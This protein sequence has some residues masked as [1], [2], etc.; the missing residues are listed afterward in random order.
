MKALQAHDN[1]AVRRCAVAHAAALTPS[2][3]RHQVTF[4][5]VRSLFKLATT[6]VLSAR[7]PSSEWELAAGTLV[8][9]CVSKCMMQPRESNVSAYLGN[10]CC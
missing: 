6:A 7:S 4:L 2:L 1:A 3:P 5:D 10:W 8:C 9:F